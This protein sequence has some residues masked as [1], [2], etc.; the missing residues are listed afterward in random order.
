MATEFQSRHIS[1]S[2]NRLFTACHRLEYLYICENS[3]NFTFVASEIK[4]PAHLRYLALYDGDHY[5]QSLLTEDNCRAMAGSLRG[6]RLSQR[7]RSG[8]FPHLGLLTNLI[9]LGVEVTPMNEASILTALPSMSSLQSL[10]V[11]GAGQSMLEEFP[12]HCPQ[13]EHL[14]L[15]T[16]FQTGWL[17]Q[18][19]IWLEH[20]RSLHAR[21]Y[22]TRYS[23]QGSDWSW[24]ETIIGR[25]QLEY[26]R[27]NIGDWVPIELL[28]TLLRRCKVGRGHGE[29]TDRPLSCYYLHQAHFRASTHC[30]SPSMTPLGGV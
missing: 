19:G 20:L 30:K 26:L 13:L 18:M 4:L 16:V 23:E 3:S 12:A 27:L 25:G 14:S 22:S 28:P 2:L 6:L 24:L 29:E 9:Y 5:I 11:G 10:E 17:K 1:S 7:T 8:P 21:C 15:S